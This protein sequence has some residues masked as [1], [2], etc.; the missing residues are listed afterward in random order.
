MRVK[1]MLSTASGGRERGERLA[2][3]GQSEGTRSK[4]RLGLSGLPMPSSWFASG[5]WP[6]SSVLSADSYG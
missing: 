2:P 1:Q 3:R 4:W 5:L 6:C